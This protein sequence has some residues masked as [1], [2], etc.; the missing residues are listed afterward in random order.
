MRF[1]RPGHAAGEQRPSPEHRSARPCR[2]AERRSCVRRGALRAARGERRPGRDATTISSKARVCRSRR[3]DAQSARRRLNDARPG[4]NRDQQQAITVLLAQLEV[5]DRK[6]QAALDLLATLQPP[7]TD[8]VLRDAAAARGQALFQLGRHADAVRALV[9]REVWLEDSAAILANQRMIWDGFRQYPPPAQLAPTGDRIVDGWLALAPLATSG[10]HEPAAIAAR[11]ARDVHGPPRRGRT[12]CGAPVRTARSRLPRADRSAV[13]ADVA[14]AHR[15]ARDS[16]RL[17]R[18]APTQVKR[19][20][21]G[22]SN[23]RHAAGRA[24]ERVPS[25]TAR[26]SRFHRRPVAAARGRASDHAGGLR[27][28][29]RAEFRANRDAAAAQLLS[30]LVGPRRR[31]ARDRG[32]HREQRR[33]HGDRVRAGHRPRLSH[34]RELQ[35]AVRGARR[36]VA[37]LRPLRAGVT[38]F[39]EVRR[40]RAEHHAQQPETAPARSKPRH[41]GA[42]RA[43]APRGR[44]RDLHHRRRH[45]RGAA[46]RASATL[47]LGG[48][49]SDL[50]DLRHLR[51]GQHGT[52]TTT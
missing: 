37:R 8:P 52:A 41:A 36:Q 25:S 47:E 40:G 45:T 48:R 51:P 13:T 11:V 19:R 7:S 34:A 15:G 43:A 21:Y 24:A 5:G 20:E 4:A 49:H 22:D 39:L 38:G 10:T 28:D 17:P 33:H 44:R 31:G 18:R 14:A 3:G 26:R 27:S 9:E 12:P 16:R 1:E 32:L 23:L 6:P 2:R 46:A 35:D 29:A 30:I 50:R 42:I